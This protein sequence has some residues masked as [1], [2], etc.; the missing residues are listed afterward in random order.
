MTF[1]TSVPPFLR[2]ST[3]KILTPIGLIFLKFYTGNFHE[4]SVSA[5]YF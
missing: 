2:L 1:V 5:F 3:R 4:K